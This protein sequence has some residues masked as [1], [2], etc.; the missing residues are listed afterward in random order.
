MRFELF[1]AAR[2]LRARRRRGVI[3]FVTAISVAGVATGVAALILALA[4]TNGMR[5]DLQDRLV[6]ASAHVELMRSAGDGMRDWRP[7]M[8]RLATVPA[9]P[10]RRPR[11]L[12]TG[13]HLTRPPL[14]R[15]AHQRHRP[16][17]RATRQRASAEHP[18]RLRRP[19]SAHQ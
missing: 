12:R 19:T 5:R 18:R 11:P 1:I 7:L 10:G 4:I 14:R 3:G 6:G 15:C 8:A 17:R 9:R 16:R 2:Y 13:P